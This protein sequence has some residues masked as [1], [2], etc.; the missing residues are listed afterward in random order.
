[1]PHSASYSPS[2]DW[3]HFERLCRALLSKI[4]GKQFQRWGRNGQFQN[5]VDLYTLTK[6]NKFIALQCKGKGDGFGQN[7]SI[8]EID[9]II[10][11]ISKFP[12]KIDHLIILTTAP[13][14]RKIQEY[15]VRLTQERLEQGKCEISLWG[16]NTICDHIGLYPDI[17]KSF[18]GHWFQRLTITQWCLR[19]FFIFI[20]LLIGYIGVKQY[21]EYKNDK[22]QQKNLS[23]T[24]LNQALDLT[25]ELGDSYSGCYLELNKS[26]FIFSQEFK[27]SCITPIESALANFDK[28]I[29]DSSVFLSSVSLEEI[30][31][32]KKIM[33][34]DYRQTLITLTSINMFE[35]DVIRTLKHACP[36]QNQGLDK[37]FWQDSMKNSYLLGKNAML[38]QLEYYFLL[39]DYILPSTT[40][41]KSRIQIQARELNGEK[42][43]QNMVDSANNLP[44]LIDL[45]NKLSPFEPKQPFSMAPVKAYS[46]RDIVFDIPTLAENEIDIEQ[47]RWNE[48]YLKAQLKSLQSRPKDIEEL[49]SCGLLEPK[50]R[51]ELLNIK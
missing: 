51:D 24:S 50:A 32:I 46:I 37:S 27:E 38:R 18:Y 25:N 5:G 7:F 28:H 12:R 45:R 35:E 40:A 16:W 17:Q 10:K 1:M 9:Q 13:D 2:R 49:I 14:D 15:V 11:D 36:T 23:L 31:A 4:Y 19:S 20:L 26:N 33:H 44:K 47:L 30:D 29:E 43:P 39:R 34:E 22:L 3:Q 6:N 21:S 8:K 48:V 41:I 42:N